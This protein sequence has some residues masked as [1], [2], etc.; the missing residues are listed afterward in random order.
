MHREACPSALSEKVKL[1][2]FRGSDRG[3]EGENQQSKQAPTD[4]EI[5]K[6]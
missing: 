4:K 6:K 5:I 3:E 1:L 2:F